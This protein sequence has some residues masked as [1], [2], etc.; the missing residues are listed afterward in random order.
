MHQ[1]FLREYLNRPPSF[2]LTRKILVY[3]KRRKRT[4][5]VEEKKIVYRKKAFNKIKYAVRG[6]GP[7]M[8]WLIK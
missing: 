4:K 3:W 6:G 8:I 2:P 7:L 5:I 1:Q